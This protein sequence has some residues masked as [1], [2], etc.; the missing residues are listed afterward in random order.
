MFHFH[1]RTQIQSFFQIESEVFGGLNL[2]LLIQMQIS[3]NKSVVSAFTVR[4]GS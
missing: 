3:V 2:D 4:L 1:G